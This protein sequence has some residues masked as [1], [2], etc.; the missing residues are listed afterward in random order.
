MYFLWLLARSQGYTPQ[1]LKQYAHF[2]QHP[3]QQ[4]QQQQQGKQIQTRYVTTSAIAID[5]PKKSFFQLDFSQYSWLYHVQ[6]L[7]SVLQAVEFL[8]ALQCSAEQT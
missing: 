7:L 1:Q 3:Q 8:Q 4:Q 6:L 5:A 2:L